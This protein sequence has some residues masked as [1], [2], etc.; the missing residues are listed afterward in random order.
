MQ[1]NPRGVL[2]KDVSIAFCTLLIQVDYIWRMNV[3]DNYKTCISIQRCQTPQI[4]LNIRLITEREIYTDLHLHLIK[5]N[6]LRQFVCQLHCQLHVLVKVP[7]FP[8]SFKYSCK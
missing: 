6:F 4:H 3:K 5:F 2:I 1:I 8:W 7:L